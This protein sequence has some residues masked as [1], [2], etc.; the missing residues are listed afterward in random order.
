MKTDLNVVTLLIVGRPLL[1]VLMAFKVDE[2][3]RDETGEHER[4]VQ[5]QLVCL[6]WIRCEQMNSAALSSTLAI[7]EC[8][9]A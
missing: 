8:Q 2:R 4:H 1:A 7:E 9:A 5:N 6:T 3:M